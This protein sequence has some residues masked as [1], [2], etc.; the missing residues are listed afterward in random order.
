VDAPADEIF[1]TVARAGFSQPRKQLHNSLKSGLSLPAETV[2]ALLAA[3][4]IAPQRR[5]E[6]LTLEEWGRLA[7]VYGGQPWGASA[8]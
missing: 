5:A 2:Q 6:T 8:T 1:F 3:A 4:E 7:S